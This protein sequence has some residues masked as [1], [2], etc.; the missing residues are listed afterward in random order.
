[1]LDKQIVNIRSEADNWIHSFNEAVSQK[2]NK[3]ESIKILSDL[4]FEDCHWRD[5][6]GLTWKIQTVSEK[7]KIIDKLYNS[8]LEVSA[9]DFQIDQ[10]RTLP[11]EVI[12]GGKS[13]IEVILKFN[14]KFGECEGVV[15]L[16]E[17]HDEQRTFKAWSF[18]TALCELKN[19]NN[20]K[21]EK[22]QI[23][24]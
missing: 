13:V 6:L 20:Q 17:N 23:L 8:I 18:M 15:R 10:K 1:M 9:K 3:D 21:L 11:R 12:R 7:S 22:Y 5:I 2:K 16:Y 24:W 14:T 19:S 4:F